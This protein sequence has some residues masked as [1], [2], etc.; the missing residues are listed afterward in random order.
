MPLAIPLVTVQ[1]SRAEPA[2][3][4]CKSK[5][6]SSAPA[7][8]HWYYRVNRADQRHCWYL[9]AEGAK[10]R[11]Q[12]REGALRVSRPAEVAAREETA[13][14]TQ[15]MP[16]LMQPA[17][18][19]TAE[20]APVAVTKDFAAPS[21]DLAKSPAL[22]TRN[23]TSISTSQ[24]EDHEPAAAQEEMPLIWPVLSESDRAG[25][26]DTAREFAPWPAV[27]VGA[28]ALLLAGA[29]FKFARRQARSF[30]RPRRQVARLRTT[31]RRR[32]YSGHTAA[33]A[34]QVVRKSALRTQRDDAAW[35]PP[36]STDPI[37]ATMPREFIR[38]SQRTAA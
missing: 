20:S 30:C 16:P 22:T 25:V 15:A 32:A 13:Q 11:A 19:K 27:L 17:Q 26:A 21:P 23:P 12:A 34:D 14:T 37:E 35:Q 33:R 1:A 28:L 10:V 24:M 6:D 36:T 4:E 31:Q 2:A 8:S 29:I 7:D 3:N 9:G 38:D 18:T 5:P